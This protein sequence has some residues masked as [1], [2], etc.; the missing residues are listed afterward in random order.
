MP[1]LYLIL[2]LTLICGRSF[3]QNMLPKHL[4]FA[5]EQMQKGDYIYAIE[6]YQKAMEIDSNTIDIL[7]KMAEAQRAYKDYRKAEFYYQKIYK[8]CL[9]KQSSKV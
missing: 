4:Q 6:H 5:D 2:F 1:R 8:H 9:L 7:W 3:G